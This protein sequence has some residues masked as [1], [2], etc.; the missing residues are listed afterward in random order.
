MP[1][2][3]QPLTAKR[4]YPHHG[5]N[6]GGEQLD[7]WSEQSLVHVFDHT[8]ERASMRRLKMRAS[9]NARQT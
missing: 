7:P 3:A 8:R 5:A 1:T 2:D 9:L 6:D 4:A